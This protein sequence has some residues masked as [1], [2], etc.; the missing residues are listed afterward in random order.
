VV[1]EDDLNS[2]DMHKPGILGHHSHLSSF[3]TDPLPQPETS[4]SSQDGDGEPAKQS[5]CSY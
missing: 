4:Q 5:Q 2:S 3:P 1:T